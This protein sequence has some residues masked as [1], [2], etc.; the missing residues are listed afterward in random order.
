MPEQTGEGGG[1]L[2]VTG[3]RLLVSEFR[4]SVLFRPR[5]ETISRQMQTTF[6]CSRS[7][8]M[9]A[10]I[11]GFGWLSLACFTELFHAF[12]LNYF[13]RSVTHETGRLA[14]TSPRG[15]TF[16][17]WVC[18]GLCL[19]HKPSELA[20][21]FH[22]VLVSVSVFMALST[23]FHS[24]DSPDNSSLSHCSSDLISAS[25]ALS[26]ISLRKSPVALI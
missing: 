12:L 2:S 23:V 7:R 26:T 22:T 11:F 6:S 13:H 14:H 10:A 15:I 18:Y 24:M 3:F 17:W 19:R 20:H 21:S 1:G 4:L 16:S 8:C 25:L 5:G 9:G